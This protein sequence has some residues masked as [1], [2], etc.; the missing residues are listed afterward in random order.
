MISDD[1][2]PFYNPDEFA[3]IA[4]WSPR[5]GGPVQEAPVIFS[6]EDVDAGMTIGTTSKV[7]TMRYAATNFVGLDKDEPIEMGDE[8]YIVRT[9]PEAIGSGLER[10]VELKRVD[11]P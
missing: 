9:P 8:I 4:K 2:E 11:T 7:I 3:V 1:L 10:R 5:S 6:E